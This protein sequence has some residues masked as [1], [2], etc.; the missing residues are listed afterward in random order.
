MWGSS[1]EELNWRFKIRKDRKKK[2]SLRL[3]EVRGTKLPL[4]LLAVV[5]VL[6]LAGVVGVSEWWLG[7]EDG[8][9]LPTGVVVAL[10]EVPSCT[11]VATELEAQTG[12]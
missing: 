3:E 9:P 11:E 4:V 5:L 8:V 2:D 1:R 10:A 12:W 6:W 7:T